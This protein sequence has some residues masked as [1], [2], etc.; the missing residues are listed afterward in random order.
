MAY[1]FFFLLKFNMNL[2]IF[3]SFTKVFCNVFPIN[4]NSQLISDYGLLSLVVWVLDIMWFEGFGIWWVIKLRRKKSSGFYQSFE[5]LP[6]CLVQLIERERLETTR[7]RPQNIKNGILVPS[8]FLFSRI[9]KDLQISE[10]VPF[11]LTFDIIYW[12]RPKCLTHKSNRM[13][14]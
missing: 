4:D 1:T 9:S 2:V 14:K 5:C 6:Q 7:L 12:R 13:R 3:Y 11:L 8:T 10:L